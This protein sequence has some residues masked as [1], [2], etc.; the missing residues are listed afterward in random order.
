MDSGNEILTAVINSIRE[1]VGEEW[2]DDEEIGLNTSFG[3]DLELESI[4]FV[5]LAEQLQAHYGE[6]LDFVAWLSSKQLDEI[7]ELTVGDVVEFIEE[8][9]S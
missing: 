2:I 5:A 9:L 6:K 1:V 7:I 3:D 8:C 4:E